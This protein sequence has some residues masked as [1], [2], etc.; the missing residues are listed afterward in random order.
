MLSTWGKMSLPLGAPRSMGVTRRT[1]SPSPPG[2]RGCRLGIDPVGEGDELLAELAGTSAREIVDS[3]DR[4]YPRLREP[5][6]LRRVEGPVIEAQG[7]Y[8]RPSIG[9]KRGEELVLGRRGS[10]VGPRDEDASV[11]DSRGPLESSHS[12]LA[13]LA[14]VV[15]AGRV[16][17]HGG[18]EADRARWA[19]R[20]DRSSC[21][22]RPRR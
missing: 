1:R 20:R 21:P 16:V 3:H 9:P 17:D 8:G 4:I 18:P 2:P 11:G 12:E 15:D 5:G 7:D 13:E 19:E 10:E 14:I 6:L 22:A